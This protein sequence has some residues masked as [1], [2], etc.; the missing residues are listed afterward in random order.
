MSP[1]RD[2]GE[3]E[4]GAPG[5][6]D[7]GRAPGR[8]PVARGDLVAP[9]IEAVLA[10]LGMEQNRPV[11]AGRPPAAAP[12][13]GLYRQHAKEQ[14]TLVEAAITGGDVEVAGTA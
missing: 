4:R 8:R 7:V 10:E 11:Y 12:A 1:V 6:L 3:A 14:A 13:T 5:R 2:E 9:R